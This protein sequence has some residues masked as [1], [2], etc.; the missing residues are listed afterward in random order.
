MSGTDRRKR[1]SAALNLAKVGI[2]LMCDGTTLYSF[3]HSS[4]VLISE[5]IWTAPQG[6]ASLFF[7][8]RGGTGMEAVG[9]LDNSM[10]RSKPAAS[11]SMLSYTV[12]HSRTL[13]GSATSQVSSQA[14][15]LTCPG[16]NRY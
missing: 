13:P 14:D 11:G 5:D 7:H 6:T 3:I 2:D 10:E 8:T 4:V 12:I 15:F 1:S 9:F 16:M